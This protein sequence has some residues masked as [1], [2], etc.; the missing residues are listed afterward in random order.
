MYLYITLGIV[1]SS[2]ILTLILYGL[3]DLPTWVAAGIVIGAAGGGI[4]WCMRRSAKYGVYG[5]LK[6]TATSN[7]PKAILI[8]SVKPFAQL[9]ETKRPNARKRP[10]AAGRGK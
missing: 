4:G 10:A 8:D 2:L 3:F 5:E 7:Q 9:R 1:F 6:K